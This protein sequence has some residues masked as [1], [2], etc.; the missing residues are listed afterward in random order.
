MVNR[1][2][3]VGLVA[4][5]VAF[6]VLLVVS[7][8]APLPG[9]LTVDGVRMAA[10]VAL[11]ATWWVT[12]AIPIPATSLL[13]IVLFPALGIMKSA[14]ATR[15]YGHHLIYLFIGGFFL[16][17]T[18]ERWGL[19]RRIALH[20]IAIMGTSPRR[21]ILGFMTAT[22]FLS[23]WVSNTATA[24]M[25]LPVGLAVIS[26][27]ADAQS[28]GD[29][30]RLD[31]GAS[32]SNFAVALMLGVAYGASIGG[33]GT[34]I[35][36]PPNAV[37]AGVVEQQFGRS[38]GF[39]RWML[40]GLPLSATF[41]A[42]TWF[43]LTRVLHPP[44]IEAIP[45]GKAL[46]EAE[47]KRLGP[48]RTAEKRVLVVFL[49]VAAG[50]IVRGFVHTSMVADA[51]IAIAGGVALFL[52]PSGT[53]RG[54]FLLDW[55]TAVT[56]PWGVVVLFGGGLALASGIDKVGLAAWLG[57]HLASMG[58]HQIG[59]V[60]AAVVLFTIFLT[61]L[62]SN[63][64]TASLLVPIMGSTAV[65]MAVHPFGLMVG[66]CVAASY[67]FMLPV[68]TPPNAVVFGSGQ[69]SIAKMARAGVWMNLVGTLLILAFALLWLPLVWGIDLG[70]LPAW[71]QP[72]R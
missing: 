58:L 11:M 16:A 18:I 7:S 4:G 53:K 61:E 35:G 41:L 63:T 57:A 55:E 36:T 34:L 37:M 17:K 26:Q 32:G 30:A 2:R 23:M 67:A 25:M 59:L 5:P 62:T 9:R 19:H 69:L 33:V 49:A 6:G 38:I 72:G 27:V 42:I 14:D 43:M 20:I 31:T 70:A 45:G 52:V 28:R 47:L 3:R 21:I 65:A 12:E 15:P 56:I 1:T 8:F 68:A 13:P 46:V 48:I 66:A 60:M 44:E 22:A 51:T 24:M 29:G 40:F 71:A 64:A 50:W 39:A 54:T 10:V